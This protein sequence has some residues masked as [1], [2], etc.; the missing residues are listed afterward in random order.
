MPNALAE[1][2]ENPFVG[3]GVWCATEHSM[4]G[5]MRF[6]DKKVDLEP[7]GSAPFEASYKFTANM[8]GKQKAKG[9]LVMTLKTGLQSKSNYEIDGNV[10]VLYSLGSNNV[11]IYRSVRESEAAACVDAQARK[12]LSKK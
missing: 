8:I 4:P 12:V 1:L 2:V 7:L 10:F 9:E 5:T 6:T 11:E 3:K